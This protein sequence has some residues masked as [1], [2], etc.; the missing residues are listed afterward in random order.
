MDST[1]NDKESRTEKSN[2][3]IGVKASPI[4][5]LL[6]IM[7]VFFLIKYYGI[8]KPDLN[9]GIEREGRSDVEYLKTVCTMYNNYKTPLTDEFAALKLTAT[10]QSTKD[11]VKSINDKL[12]RLANIKN[13]LTRHY[14][15]FLDY[16]CIIK[17]TDG[18]TVAEILNEGIIVGEIIYTKCYII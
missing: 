7:M 17:N 16:P 6:S 9:L 13:I 14:S 15:K 1:L 3:R 2:A 11:M 10:E 4:I 5:I 8:R 18:R 12:G